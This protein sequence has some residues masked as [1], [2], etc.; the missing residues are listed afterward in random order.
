MNRILKEKINQ[1]I[2][3]II[4]LYLLPP[5][6]KTLN[7]SYLNNTISCIKSRLN[8]HNI[9]TI[10]YNPIQ[11]IEYCEKFDNCKIFNFKTLDIWSIRMKN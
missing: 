1:Y 5:L 4:G 11:N 6:S 2:I 7:I 3:R 9:L 10:N 8:S